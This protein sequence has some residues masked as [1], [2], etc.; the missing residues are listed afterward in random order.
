[1]GAISPN[2]LKLALKG[3]IDGGYEEKKSGL[4][5]RQKEQT[6]SEQITEA[7]IGR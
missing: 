7:L 4:A 2:G 3:K 6:K 5:F 1:M